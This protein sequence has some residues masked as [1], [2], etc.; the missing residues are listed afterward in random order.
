MLWKW[1]DF[2]SDQTYLFTQDKIN[3]IKL[4]VHHRFVLIC[5]TWSYGQILPVERRPRRPIRKKN[6]NSQV[7]WRPLLP[8]N[9][10]S[11]CC[12][13]GSGHLVL[14]VP[15]PRGGQGEQF[16]ALTAASRPPPPFSPRRTKEDFS[17]P[18]SRCP[19]G[20]RPPGAGISRPCG[21]SPSTTPLT[22]P[23]IT[24]RLPEGLCSARRQEVTVNRSFLQKKISEN[25][26]KGHEK[27]CWKLI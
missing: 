27:I 14:D 9:H 1:P 26:I 6:Y 13:G 12:F 17:P 2:K 22:C 11:L 8:A 18:V 7:R 19:R 23:R 16:C 24:P 4:I 15:R 5:V 25:Q 10:G 21:G 20:A 3:N